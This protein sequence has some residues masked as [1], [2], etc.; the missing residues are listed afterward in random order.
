MKTLL[1]FNKLVSLFSIGILLIVNSTKLSAQTEIYFQ[2][3]ETNNDWTFTQPNISNS[4]N[5]WVYGN[6]TAGATTG[7][8]TFSGA[9]SL[10]IWRRASNAWN[11]NYGGHNTAGYSRTVSKVFDFS[12]YG[13]QFIT[14]SFWVLVNAEAN[15]DDLRVV[16]NGTV[17]DGPLTNILTWQQRQIDLTAYAGLNNVT[18]AF[19]WRNDGSVQNQPA[20]RLDDIRVVVSAPQAP[21]CAAS[22]TAPL[23]EATNVGL[24]QQLSWPTVSGAT[25]YDVYFGTSNPATTL[26]SSNQIGTTY[27]PGTLDGT[28]TYYWSIVPRNSVGSASGCATWSFT[29][30]VPGCNNGT[31]YTTFKPACT[32][33]QE[34][35]AA[36][37][38]AG[39]YNTLTLTAG[40]QYTFGSSNASDYITITDNAAG[41]ITAGNQPINFTPLVAGQYRVYI[42][43]N[44]ACATANVCRTPWVQCAACATSPSSIEANLSN[45]VVNDV[46]IY[47]VS[48]GNG[49]IVNYEFSYDNFM[50]IAGT[51]NSTANPLNLFVNALQPQ[52]SVR[53][54]TQA[55]GCIPI[56]S[57]FVTTTLECATV[58]TYGTSDGD[59]ITNVSLNSINNN[60]TSDTGADAY[61]DFT[62]ISTELIKNME[63]PLSVS[64]TT[65]FQSSSQGFAVWIDWNGDGV[66]DA[67]ENVLLSDPAP[68]AQASVIVPEN[69]IT[70]EVKMRVSCRWAGTPSVN[71]C[72]PTAYGWGEIE[73]YTINILEASALPVELIAF[74]AQCQNDDVEVNWSTATEHNSQYFALQ[75]SEDGYSWSDLYV[76]EAAGFSTTVLEY[77]YIHKNAARTKNYY[78][79]RQYDNDG[80]V[81]TYNTI[82]SNCTS[83]EY[84]FMTFPNPSAD[85]F[86]VLVNDKLLSG[87]NVLN[88]SDASGKLIYS[89][90]VDLENGSGSFALEG[91]DLPAGLYYLQLNNGSHTSRVIKHSF[92]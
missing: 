4:N 35:Y 1:Q 66:F 29:T 54:T 57:D 12:A 36:C 89:I 3:F 40:T 61:Q 23:D 19:E 70:G 24:T 47:S 45:T 14:F 88:I 28:T 31:S 9:R 32:G 51:I 5:Y 21:S 37:T 65:T 16:V 75:V 50:T 20:A 38:Y 39:E 67:S 44:A 64:G 43:T 80:T 82:M 60:S 49:N 34:N 52:I 76:I 84:L 68:S 22:P 15:F 46:V 58:I 17:L 78:R 10:Q 69:A 91:L 6:G 30:R 25:G 48:G 7:A 56:P 73:E 33:A 59:F 26:V 74:T 8:A 92:R 81:E 18:V 85:A 71:A 42:H 27:N 72:D 55:A 87:S 2:D 77:S 79:L 62:S 63:Y 13:G 83:D 90:A 53:V 41:I 86:T 11:A